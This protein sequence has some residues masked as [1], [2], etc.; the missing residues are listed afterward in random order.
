MVWLEILVARVCLKGSLCHAGNALAL[1]LPP[2]PANALSLS[3]YPQQSL[4]DRAARTAPAPLPSTIRTPTRLPSNNR[5][6]S[7]HH[8]RHW[9]PILLRHSFDR[10]SPATNSVVTSIDVLARTS[11]S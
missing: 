2:R 1:P 10:T 3:F 5:V 6:C 8:S 4:S 11:T 9:L 7:R